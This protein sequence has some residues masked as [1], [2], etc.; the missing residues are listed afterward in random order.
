M[1]TKQLGLFISNVVG[2]LH[3]FLISGIK[4]KQFFLMASSSFDILYYK[5]PCIS[6]VALFVLL[7]K[8]LSRLLM[9]SFPFSS[10]RGDYVLLGLKLISIKSPL[11][12]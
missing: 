3:I 9:M 10:F 1:Q 4:M 8:E 7:S 11:L 12:S 5:S 6:V 2:L